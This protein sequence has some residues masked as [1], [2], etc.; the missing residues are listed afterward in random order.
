M[1][2][3]SF[4]FLALAALMP[5]HRGDIVSRLNYVLDTTC[6]AEVTLYHIL[7]AEFPERYQ[8]EIPPFTIGPLRTE[9]LAYNCQKAKS[10]FYSR[11]RESM[12][13]TW[14]IERKPMAVPILDIPRI[15]ETI[16]GASIDRF[17]RSPSDMQAWELIVNGYFSLQNTVLFEEFQT[18][19]VSAQSALLALGSPFFD[20]RPLQMLSS[21]IRTHRVAIFLNIGAD[22]E[23][24]VAP[25]GMGP[26]IIELGGINERVPLLIKE[27]RQCYGFERFDDSPFHRSI[28]L[29]AD[30]VARGRQHELENWINAIYDVRSN[31]YMPVQT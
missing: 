7:A 11:Y 12:A 28:K 20:P 17:V 25:G 15:R 21:V 24:F 4:S 3:L 16:F 18:E 2:T 1:M 31:M 30:F 14:T 8:F 29:F 23:G 6:D 10:D 27:L 19:M 26:L 22:K 13:Q 9:K 5:S